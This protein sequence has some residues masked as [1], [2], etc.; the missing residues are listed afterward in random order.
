ML[1]FVELVRSS[2]KT[3]PELAP[4]R[5]HRSPKAL[6]SVATKAGSDW[7]RG[8]EYRRSPKGAERADESIARSAPYGVAGPEGHTAPDAPNPRATVHE[9]TKRS[10]V[11]ALVQPSGPPR[12]HARAGMTLP[13]AAIVDT[14]LTSREARDVLSY[15]HATSPESLPYRTLHHQNR[16]SAGQ[17]AL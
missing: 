17:L 14:G 7:R 16:H 1:R 8:G 5:C 9:A 12:S 15:R 2:G 4:T 3:I 11:T 10:P 6:P 13:P